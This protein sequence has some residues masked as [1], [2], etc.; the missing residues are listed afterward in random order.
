MTAIFTTTATV[1]GNGKS[2]EGWSYT[3]ELMLCSRLV[4]QA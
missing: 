1:D 4:P 2:L 3:E